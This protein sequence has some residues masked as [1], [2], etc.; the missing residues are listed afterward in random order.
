MFQE[1]RLL[2]VGERH[3]QMSKSVSVRG[4]AKPA[5]ASARSTRSRR[6]ASLTAP[7]T[8]RGLY[9]AARSSASPWRGLWSVG[10]VC[11]RSTNRLAR[12][13]R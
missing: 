5:R 1:P 10:R 11:L 3:R 6:S 9:P 7:P 13:T 4:D 8:G 2:A 12:S